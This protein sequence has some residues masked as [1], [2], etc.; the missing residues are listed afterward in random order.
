[1]NRRAA[2]QWL[3][4]TAVGGILGQWSGKR[5]AQLEDK[6]AAV[7]TSEPVTALAIQRPT[8]ITLLYDI[9]ARGYECRRI[10]LY[11]RLYQ[12]GQMVEFEFQRCMDPD[13]FC[14]KYFEDGQ[15]G[16]RGIATASLKV[17]PTGQTTNL[18]DPEARDRRL[19]AAA[20]GI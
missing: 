14:Q 12:T 7:S 3:M 17:T 8:I 16:T 4:G 1:M 20:R 9:S 18:G 6:C 5:L 19:E 13:C 11:K 10:H 2:V 15:I